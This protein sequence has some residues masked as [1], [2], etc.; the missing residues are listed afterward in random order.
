MNSSTGQE[1]GLSEYQANLE[2]YM[3]VPLFSGLPPEPLKLLAYL[4][5]RETFKPGEYIF[6][7][8]E[9]DDNAYYFISGSALL[10]LED[11][12]ENKTIRDLAEG[13][14][15]GGLSLFCRTKRLFSAQATSTVVCLILTK[16]KFEKTLEQFPVITRKILEE[17]L[18]GVY[19]WEFRFVNEHALRC[20]DCLGTLGVSLV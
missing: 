19:Q 16:E 17:I 20:A 15:I 14:F 9:S 4:S 10:T 13:D 5:A 18:A 6:R 8:G 3:Q 2:V 12:G 7:Q 1:Q 11:G